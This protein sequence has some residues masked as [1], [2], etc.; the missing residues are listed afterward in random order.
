[1]SLS[2]TVICLIACHGG[3]ADHF[4][5]FAEQLVQNGY[6]VQVYAS[7][8]ALKKFQDRNIQVA[9]SF[10]AD[11]LSAE[12]EKELAS[13]IAKSCSKAAVV[14]TDVGHAFDINLQKALSVED[15]QVLRLAYYDNP[16]PYVPGGYSNVAADVMLAAKKVLFANANLAAASL[17]QEPNMEIKL[18][19]QDRIGLGYYPINQAEKM[20]ARRAENHNSM[21][22]QFFS[23]HRLEDKGQKVLVYFGG[24]NGEYFKEAFPAFLK[25]LSEGMQQTD[26]SNFVVVVQQHPGA[27]TKN[28]DREQ[29]ETWIKEK[30]ENTTA[31]KMIISDGTSDDM[32]V[33]AD[34][35]LYYQTSMGPLFALAGI[36]MVQVGHKTYEDVLVRG[37][38]CPSATNSV[39]FIR[40]IKAIK[41]A[42]VSEEQK[43]IIFKSLGIKEDWFNILKQAL[44]GKK[45]AISTA[46]LSAKR[47]IWP[48]VLAAGGIAAISYLAA[49]F[50][51][52]ASTLTT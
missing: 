17:Y 24:N 38:L 51:Y 3:P 2:A 16:E 4:A 28:I 12:S 21:R 26:L 14:L 5:T 13:Q 52:T 15:S 50:F 34:G 41:P 45:E 47:S 22:T 32:Q 29:A 40:S 43:R 25:F 23:A 37:N 18:P 35:A 49:R 20:A 6:E 30:G 36:P 10:S 33:L 9:M 46:T 44:A 31:P 7:G 48:Y 19:L 1:M 39:D 42:A 11:N 8:P 27:K